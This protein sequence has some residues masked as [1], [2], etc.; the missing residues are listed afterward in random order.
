MS[1]WIDVAPADN[2]PPGSWLTLDLN[3]EEI[4]VFNVQGNYYAVENICSH[5]GGLLTGG[6]LE[7][8]QVICPRHGARFSILTGEAMSPPAYEPIA[9]FPTRLESGMVQI[10]DNRWG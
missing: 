8:H 3:G 2:L 1:E 7:D 10:K 5:D 6:K 9:T 4:A